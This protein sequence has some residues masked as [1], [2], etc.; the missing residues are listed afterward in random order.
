MDVQNPVN[1]TGEGGW[2][3][4]CKDLLVDLSINARILDVHLMPSQLIVGLDDF[5]KTFS[6]TLLGQISMLLISQI[7]EVNVVFITVRSCTCSDSFEN[8]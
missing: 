6:Y 4:P 7:V 8:I 5:Y 1:A 2:S 3:Y